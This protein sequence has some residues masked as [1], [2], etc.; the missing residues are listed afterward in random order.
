MHIQYVLAPSSGAMLEYIDPLRDS[1]FP[2]P[3]VLVMKP[4]QAVVGMLGS[5]KTVTFMFKSGANVRRLS[6]CHTDV[7][8]VILP[9]LIKYILLYVG[10]CGSAG[11]ALQESLPPK[12]G[13]H[14]MARGDLRRG[15]GG[16][17]FA[18]DWHKVGRFLQ[19]KPNSSSV[20]TNSE[21]SMHH[22]SSSLCSSDTFI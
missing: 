6:G 12:S 18:G 5:L 20:H 13:R 10:S 22:R 17:V 1:G 2:S 11:F 8:A 21:S 4:I 7:K 9:M 14:N 3:K 16:H 15:H 19:I